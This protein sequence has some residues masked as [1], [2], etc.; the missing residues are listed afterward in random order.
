MFSWSRL[1]KLEHFKNKRGSNHRVSDNI[2]SILKI[3]QD[4]FCCS[5][6]KFLLTLTIIM[7]SNF[8]VR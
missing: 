2:S 1:E 3:S 4:L 6:L 5:N 8:T 7:T